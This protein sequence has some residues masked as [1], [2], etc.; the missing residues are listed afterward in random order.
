[1]EFDK[2]AKEM[3]CMLSYQRVCSCKLECKKCMLYVHVGT[4][5]LAWCQAMA[6]VLNKLGHPWY[7]SS[8]DCR[9]PPRC[10]SGSPR[11]HTV[12]RQTPDSMFN[13]RSY[14]YEWVSKWN[15]GN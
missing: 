7:G 10:G 4:R 5:P 1:M 15:A 12:G 2:T 9:R 14:V 8:I 3:V 13:T 6:P 11:P